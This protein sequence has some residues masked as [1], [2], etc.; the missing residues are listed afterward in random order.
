[1]FCFVHPN[2]LICALG[3][4]MLVSVGELEFI[5]RRTSDTLTMTTMM[6]TTMTTTMT[7]RGRRTL[8]P[9]VRTLLDRP[10]YRT[11]R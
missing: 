11:L 4:S 5:S 8:R 2:V 10:S 7:T 6:M 3:N 9:Q 1:M